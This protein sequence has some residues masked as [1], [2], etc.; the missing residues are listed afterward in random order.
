MNA[1]LIQ[2]YAVLSAALALGFSN[3]T[4]AAVASAATVSATA[5]YQSDSSGPLDLHH[6]DPGAATTTASA[7]PGDSAGTIGP[8]VDVVDG[9]IARARSEIDTSLATSSVGVY[10]HAGGYSPGFAS[11]PSTVRASSLVHWSLSF[12]VHSLPEI[13]SAQLNAEFGIDGSLLAASFGGASGVGQVYS[14]VGA[15]LTTISSLGSINWVDATATLD[16]FGGLT[17]SGPWA[18]GFTNLTSSG[19]SVA[20]AEALYHETYVGLITVPTNEVFQYEVELN[21]EAFA[22]GAF[23][24]WAVADFFNTATFDLSVTG[25]GL[26]L[27]RL[28]S[29]VPLPAPFALLLVPITLLGVAGL[30]RRVKVLR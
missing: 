18:S 20:Y 17:A 23:E 6:G 4:H 19:A 16:R 27:E 11:P 8:G 14:T 28:P 26:S 13:T 21:S 22:H 29:A 7:G 9:A 15:S 3:A 5:Q 30:K 12:I 24:N 10:S 2:R 1:R 25:P